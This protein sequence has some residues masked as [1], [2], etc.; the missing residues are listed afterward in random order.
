MAG[1]I[2]RLT[3]VKTLRLEN[4]VLR[5]KLEIEQER[6]DMLM[7]MLRNREKMI[8]NLEMQIEEGGKVFNKILV[9]KRTSELNRAEMARLIDGTIEECKE[10]HIDYEPPCKV[11]YE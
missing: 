7:E 8:T 9:Y 5:D 4:K 11:R 6:G 1:F 2:D 3:D 10:L